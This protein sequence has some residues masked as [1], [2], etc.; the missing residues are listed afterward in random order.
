MDIVCERKDISKDWCIYWREFYATF[1]FYNGLFF[2]SF[3][4]FSSSTT[5]DR[6]GLPAAWQEN[7]EEKLCMSWVA[8]SVPNSRQLI[9]ATSSVSAPISQDMISSSHLC[10]C[11]EQIIPQ[12][13][14]TKWLKQQRGARCNTWQV[15]SQ[16]NC[17]THDLNALPP[18]SSLCDINPSKIPTQ[19]FPPKILS[20]LITVYLINM[21]F[22]FNHMLV[23]CSDGL[24]TRGNK[25]FLY[26][27]DLC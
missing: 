21:S 16:I 20:P 27:C 15:Y 24:I 22:F 3:A 26:V 4:L 6:C 2:L 23:A 9:P 13:K 19:I 18:W 11:I 7:G 14:T 10:Q 12:W 8:T 5:P 17:N 1:G 25:C